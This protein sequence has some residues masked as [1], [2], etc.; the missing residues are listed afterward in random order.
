MQETRS[1]TFEKVTLLGQISAVAAF[2]K[3]PAGCHM[4]SVSY[5]ALM[6]WHRIQSII[7]TIKVQKKDF[8]KTWVF[9]GKPVE[10]GNKKK[11]KRHSTLKKKLVE[12]KDS[13]SE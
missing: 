13:A 1:C 7:I 11:E 4:V 8:P 3:I 5:R 10:D 6:R 9:T 12:N 2:Q